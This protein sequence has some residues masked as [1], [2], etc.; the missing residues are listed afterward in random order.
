MNNEQLSTQA[1]D[2]L[3]DTVR[4]KPEALLL[5]AAGCAMLL[6]SGRRPTRSSVARWG[7]GG[8]TRWDPNA[9]PTRSPSSVV[10]TVTGR[11]AEF[12]GELADKVSATADTVSDTANTYAANV[13][14]TVTDYAD[15]ARRT[16]SN[17]ADDARRNLTETS[18]R[19]FAG[20]GTC[21]GGCAWSG[22]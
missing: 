20:A 6:Y 4:R 11:A 10:T 21:S 17:Y 8:D 3:A 16:V 22:G 12:A 19:V 18:D 15:T 14:D 5:L 1:G 9:P 7:M 2:W 13:A